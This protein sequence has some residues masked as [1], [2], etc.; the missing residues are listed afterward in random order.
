VTAKLRLC[1]VAPHPPKT[2]TPD[3]PEV[4]K[5]KKRKKVTVKSGEFDAI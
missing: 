5:I 2:H 3:A 1:Y 4:A